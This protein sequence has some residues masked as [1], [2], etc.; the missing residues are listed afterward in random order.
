MWGK[1]NLFRK[2]NF[3]KVSFRKYS[4]TKPFFFSNWDNLDNN[5]WC[6][7]IEIINAISRRKVVRRTNILEMKRFH[8]P[9]KISLQ[10]E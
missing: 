10:K 2:K 6:D 8:S 7:F 4:E 3:K 1:K 9:L 5:N